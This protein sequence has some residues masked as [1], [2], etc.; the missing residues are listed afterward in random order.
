LFHDVHYVVAHGVCD[1]IAGLVRRLIHRG[2][3]RRNQSRQLARQRAAFNR[4]GDGAAVRVPHHDDQRRVQ[5]LGRVFDAGDLVVSR[6]VAGHADVEDVAEPWKPAATR[7]CVNPSHG[8][9]LP[10]CT[11]M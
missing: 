9:L 7:G 5:V 10:E 3:N 2:T 11:R 1:T 6:N 4:C 8:R